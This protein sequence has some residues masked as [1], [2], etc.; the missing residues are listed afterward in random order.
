M[1]VQ[2][3]SSFD[4]KREN[5]TNSF[6]K[7]YTDFKTLKNSCE[8]S[9]SCQWY[10]YSLSSAPATQEIARILSAKVILSHIKLRPVVC[11][12]YFSQHHSS[13]RDNKAKQYLISTVN[14]AV[15]QNMATPFILAG[16]TTNSNKLL[17]LMLCGES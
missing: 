2:T 14:V 10:N 4:N 12:L 1:Q 16:H 13:F 3:Q 6:L 17:T 5:I 7:L 8:I 9:S 15:E 11:C